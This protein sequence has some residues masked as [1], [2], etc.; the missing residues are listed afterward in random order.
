MKPEASLTID[1]RIATVS[2][3]QSYKKL[4]KF[5]RKQLAKQQPKRWTYFREHEFIYARISHRFLKISLNMAI[6]PGTCPRED[7]R[8]HLANYL[9]DKARYKAS[10][11]DIKA[12]RLAY[13]TNGQSNWRPIGG[14][15]RCE[16]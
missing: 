10:L 12:N 5:A 6:R 11:V 8:A 13:Q 16:E 4:T 3:C 7:R 9:K 15:N 14:D 2:T 1:G